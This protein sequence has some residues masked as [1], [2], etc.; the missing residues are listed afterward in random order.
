MLYPRDAPQLLFSDEPGAE[1]PFSYLFINLILVDI[2]ATLPSLLGK[3]NDPEYPQISR[4]LTSAFDVLA[5]FIGYLLAWMEEL[6]QSDTAG[7][8]GNVTFNMPPDLLLKLSKSLG[9][10]ISV[11][12]E[13]LRDR[14]D[15]SVAGAMGLHP[16]ARVGAAH[17]ATGSSH[18][19]LAW[20]AKDADTA[21]DPFTLAALRAIAL[22][23][24]DDDG[25][26]LREEAVGLMDMFLELYQRSASSPLLPSGAHQDYRLPVLAAL[27]GV[28][29]TPTGLEAFRAHDGWQTLSRDL[30]AILAATSKGQ[31]Q[32]QQQQPSS[33]YGDLLEPELL[34]GTRIAFALSIVTESESGSTPEDW[35]ALVTAVAAYDVPASTAE[36]EE[37]G[38]DESMLLD[39]QADVLQLVAG[40]LANASP[41]MRKR[42]LHSESAIRSVTEQLRRNARDDSPAASSLDDVLATLG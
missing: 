37:S 33:Y 36:G 15:A 42:Y 10:T 35:M 32:Q 21:A 12:M 28:L 41:G 11:I 14:W 34:R 29:R 2:R 1:K 8:G 27:E 7:P 23:L 13:Y 30:L 5:A 3:L 9:E 20:D 19:T 25:D 40:L 31:Q 39:F 22:W 17:A 4:R 16:D 26:A 6:D 38:M 24:R 18:K